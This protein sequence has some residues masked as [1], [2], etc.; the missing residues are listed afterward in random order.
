MRRNSTPI[1]TL[2]LVINCPENIVIV[3]LALKFTVK[4]CTL[5][6]KEEEMKRFGFRILITFAFFTIFLSILFLDR[7]FR[8]FSR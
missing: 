5:V 3:A 7:N 2:N 8:P 4:F 6:A 1:L